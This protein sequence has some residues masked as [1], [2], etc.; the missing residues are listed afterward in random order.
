MSSTLEPPVA[1][2]VEASPAA[3]KD[4]PLEERERYW[5]D[6]VYQGDD[7]PQ[8]TVRAVIMGMLLGGVMSLSNLYVGLKTGWGLGVAITACIL[9][10]AIWT[11]LHRLFP[12][13]FK[14]EMSILENNCMQ[15]TA[16]SA[17]YSTGGTMVSAIAAYVMLTGHHIPYPLLTA[18]TFFL[19]VLGVAIAVPMKRQMINVEQLVFPSGTAA[20]F[21]LRS[22]HNKGVEAMRQA[23]SL[24]AAA[25]IG[26]FV[27][28]FRDNTYK[29]PVIRAFIPDQYPLAPKWVTLAGRPLMDYT[30]SFEGSLIMIAAGAIMGFKVTWSMLAGAIVNYGVLAPWLYSH[31]ILKTLGYSAIVKWSI[32][33]GAAMMV[34]S[35]LVTFGMQWRSVARSLSSF[36]KVF[37]A[38]RRAADDPLARIEVP[39]AWFAIGAGVSGVAC[40]ALLFYAFHTALWMGAIAVVMTFFLALVAC[41]A[42]GETDITP[43]GAMGK[44]TQLTYGILAPANIL[45]NLMTACVTAGASASSAD[46]LTDLKS[47]YLL[48]ANPRQQTLAQFFGV[49]AGT[50]IVVPAFY[51]IVPNAA[52]LGTDK[53]P[54]PSAQVWAGVARLLANGIDSL[55]PSARIALLVGALLGIVFPLLEAALPKRA[56]AFVPS[57]MGVGLAFVIPFFNSLSM[58]VGAII[59]LL[60]ARFKPKAAETYV[61]PVSSGLI[62]GESLMGIAI[63]LLG[64]LGFMPS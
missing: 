60:F 13:W 4:L 25:G 41:R 42:T 28:W 59:A 33:F 34:T 16:S 22:L 47:G 62:A 21:T 6:H 29:L 56:K 23:R 54:A 32:W 51:L 14:T 43:I 17:G 3:I 50:A 38:E 12:R 48:G 36:A 44:I 27:A 11:T 26:A 40:I 10:Y 55:P 52:A 15:S 9:S 63:T 30:I 31:G 39:T 20:A 57:A 53:F 46:L 35:A 58:F 1:P 37:Q 8:L 5:F 24:F 19:A 2:V 18:W 7:M 64:A 61:I 49:F 45:T